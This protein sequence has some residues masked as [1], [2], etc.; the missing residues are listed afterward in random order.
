LLSIAEIRIICREINISTLKE[1]GGTVR[2]EFRKTVNVN[3]ERVIRLVR[4]GAGK[5]K[6]DP[7]A[8][9]VLLLQTGK[10]SLK[11]KSFFLREKLT[12]LA[13]N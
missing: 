11:E 8:P 12:T 1:K 10:I 3:V 6:L 7:S 9:N 2:I 5:V 13:S 4:E